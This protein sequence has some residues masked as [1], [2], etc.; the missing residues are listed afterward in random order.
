M[1]QWNAEVTFIFC[2]TLATLLAMVY[3]FL[4]F[5]LVILENGMSGEIPYDYSSSLECRNINDGNHKTVY[6]TYEHYQ[7]LPPNYRNK[8]YA[9]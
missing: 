5:G 1:F 6:C 4:S 2:S 9:I 8:V 7:E 3:S